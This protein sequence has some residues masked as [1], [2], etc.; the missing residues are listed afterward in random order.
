MDLHRIDRAGGELRGRGELPERLDILAEELHSNGPAH[1]RRKHVRDAAAD[2]EFAPVLDDVD[3]RV[4]Q[5]HQPGGQS[6]GRGRRARRDQER[7]VRPEIRGEALDRREGRS[8]HD[9]R[10]TSGTEPEGRLRPR[11]GGLG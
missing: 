3:P 2:R 11:P 7:F 8:G 6:V 1:R 10:T 4:A 9:Q 5:I